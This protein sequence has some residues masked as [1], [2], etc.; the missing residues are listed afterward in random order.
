M[1]TQVLVLSQSRKPTC[2]GHITHLQSEECRCYIVATTMHACM[3]STIVKFKKTTF[4]LNT[5]YRPPKWGPPNVILS[6][7]QYKNSYMSQLWSVFRGQ[8]SKA[9]RAVAVAWQAIGP[10]PDF[11]ITKSKLFVFL[12]I[13]QSQEAK[14]GKQT[15][16]TSN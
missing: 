12:D 6:Y 16:W 9:R 10:F 4:S 2:V 13:F 3:L 15:S 1:W 14:A 8:C 5:K 7:Y 11:S